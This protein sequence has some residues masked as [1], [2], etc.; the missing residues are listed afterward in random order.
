MS[1][2]PASTRAP[3][4]LSSQAKVPEPEKLRT[5]LSPVFILL[6][7]VQRVTLLTLEVS[8]YGLFTPL[9][10]LFDELRSI[11]LPVDVCVTHR[12]PTGAF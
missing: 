5:E 4:V 12:M 2:H 7:E 8:F 1:S 11:L 9:L 6:P 10:T 3:V